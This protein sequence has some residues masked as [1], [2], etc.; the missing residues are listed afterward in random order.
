MLQ[1]S[2]L[3]QRTVAWYTKRMLHHGRKNRKN[4][5]CKWQNGV[6]QNVTRKMQKIRQEGVN[7]LP[8]YSYV[9]S[10]WIISKV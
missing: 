3:D 10:D 4:C 6:S 5:K 2:M 8:V 1:S 9:T 7:I